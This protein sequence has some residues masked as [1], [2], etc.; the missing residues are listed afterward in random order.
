MDIY[1]TMV[2][3]TSLG[4]VRKAAGAITNY[5]S[6]ALALING[7]YINKDYG[8]AD[9]I[10]QIKSLTNVPVNFLKYYEEILR[11]KDIKTIFEVVH[12]FWKK[13]ENFL[14]SLNLGK[15]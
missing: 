10:E 12:N 7:S 9:R 5:L 1:K 15:Y 13:Q 4:S 2:F 8:S 6:E 3:E 11:I 14:R